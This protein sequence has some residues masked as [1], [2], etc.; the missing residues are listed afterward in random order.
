MSQQLDPTIYARVFGQGDGALVLEDLV[1]RFFDRPIYVPGGI[2]AQRETDRRA[3]RREVVA[4]IL[5]Q[6]GQVGDAETPET[7]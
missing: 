1:A 7:P 5:R 4:H 6:M 3:A 2:E